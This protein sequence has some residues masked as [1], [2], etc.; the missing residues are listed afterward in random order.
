MSMLA[1]GTANNTA[2]N[3]VAMNRI[4]GR[5]RHFYDL[6]RKYYLLGRDRVID[7]LRADGRVRVLEIGCGTGRN[8]ILAAERYKDARLFG[9]DVST[10]MLTS[11]ID[12][13][14]SAGLASRLRVGH[15]DAAVFDPARLFGQHDFERI[16]ISYS[17]SMI[18]GWEAALDRAVAMLA[19]GGEL[20]IVDFGGQSG[21]PRVFKYVLRRWLALFHVTPRDGLEKFLTGRALDVGASLTIERPYRD[22]AQVL[23]FTKK[24]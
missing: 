2:E 13:I 9:I 7:R 14:D 22:Y 21:L 5:Q 24:V 1:N 11:A 15:G 4:Y 20:H 19:P 3:T 12:K 6:T 17:L 10:A 18:P 23:K 16:F 8:L